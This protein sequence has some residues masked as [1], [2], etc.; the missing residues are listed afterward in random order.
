MKKQLTSKPFQTRL[1]TLNRAS[2]IP[3][4]HTL[5][6]RMSSS[7]GLEPTPVRDARNVVEEIRCTVVELL[8]N[9]VSFPFLCIIK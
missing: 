7:V 3:V 2:T 8:S 6:L 1:I 4:V 5:A 9:T